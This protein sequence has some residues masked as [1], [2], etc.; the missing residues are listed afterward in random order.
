[1]FSTNVSNS[2][3]SVAPTADYEV[4]TLVVE[5]DARSREDLAE[6]AR[7]ALSD[8]SDSQYDVIELLIVGP[9]EQSPMMRDPEVIA[10]APMTQ[11]GAS[12]TG[13]AL[14]DYELGAWG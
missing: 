7:T 2:S 5:T 8:H 9:G 12:L 10:T 14:G 13:I 6:V 1:M 11:Y 4:L 3:Y